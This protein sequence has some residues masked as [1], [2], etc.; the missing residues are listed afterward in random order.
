MTPA[1]HLATAQCDIM[2]TIR[3]ALR[4]SDYQHI[5]MI[6]EPGIGKTRLALEALSAEDLAPLVI[7]SPH[8]ED[9]QRN[10]LFHELLRGDLPYHAIV[11]IDECDEKDRASIWGALKG[12]RTIR[13]ITIDNGPERS[14]DDQMLVIDCPPLPE[15][16]ITAIIASYVPKHTSVWHWAQWC[17][18]SPRLAH[19]VG[20]NLQQNPE[21]LLKPPA[22]VPLW[23]RFVAGYDRL[24]SQNAR[25]AL[26]V[27]PHAALFTRFGFEDPVSGEA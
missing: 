22:T 20:E 21:D 19:A 3:K 9:F 12:R 16:Q 14:R 27:L 25:D 26:T 11:V 24:D 23:E 8:A 4:G 1:L 2:T 5:R 17:S 7:Y 10:P 6:G 13:L 15:D 18:G